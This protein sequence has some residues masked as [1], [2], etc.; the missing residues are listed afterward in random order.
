MKKLIG[1][2]TIQYNMN[3]E[4][5]SVSFNTELINKES[6]DII[7]EHAKVF[8][9]VKD[10]SHVNPAA[11]SL[12]AILFSKITDLELRDMET[13]SITHNIVCEKNNGKIVKCVIEYYLESK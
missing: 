13:T 8:N 9:D 11:D 10:E 1:I 7:K 12:L 5:D 4:V 3:Q 2:A 6:N